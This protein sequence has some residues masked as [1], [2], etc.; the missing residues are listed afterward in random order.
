MFVEEALQLPE[1]HAG[2][3]REQR[4][5]VGFIDRRLHPRQHLQHTVSATDDLVGFEAAT[6]LKIASIIGYGFQMVQTGLSDD[7]RF[8]SWDP[9]TAE[10]INQAGVS[11]RRGKPS[12][13]ITDNAAGR[14]L[15]DQ[16]GT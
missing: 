14:P 5:G 8:T 10:Y 11:L 1:R 9:A 13:V 3:V 6:Q 2:Y 16:G 4:P 15:T 12:S 7:E